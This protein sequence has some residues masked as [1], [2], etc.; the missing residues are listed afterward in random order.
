MT[1]KHPSY[2]EREDKIKKPKRPERKERNLRNAL[3]S[4][5]IEHLLEFTDDD[6][7]YEEDKT[8]K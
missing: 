2:H 6:F 5:D 8:W 7:D 1:L 3:R 4:N